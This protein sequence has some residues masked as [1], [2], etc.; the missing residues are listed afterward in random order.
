MDI[1]FILDSSGSVGKSNWQTILDFVK[2]VSRTF[3]ISSDHVQV[4]IVSFGNDA[5]LHVQLNDF[6]NIND[7]TA[8][9]DRIP[10]KDQWTNTSGGIWVTR[11][12]LF[13]PINGD[14]PDAPNYGIL[15][16]DG[17]SNKDP[18]LTLPEADTALREG[19]RLMVVGIG[20]NVNQIELKG[21]AVG[22]GQSRVSNI[23]HLLL[24]KDFQ[25]FSSSS[26]VMKI[27]RFLCREY[28]IPSFIL[29]ENESQTCM[30]PSFVYGTRLQVMN[31]DLNRYLY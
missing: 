25:E 26:T 12:R 27:I 1:A 31:L 6:D 7:L 20:S 21:I 22:S 11:T 13:S 4:G 16:T 10:W 17:E 14:R 15:V 2:D 3:H 5:T 19:I 23:Q 24:V 29:E 18:R 28:K 9:I 30:Q 8:A